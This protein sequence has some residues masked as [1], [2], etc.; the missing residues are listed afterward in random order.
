MVSDANFVFLKRREVMEIQEK[1]K[2]ALKELTKKREELY[3]EIKERL[4]PLI[5]M[6]IQ[7]TEKIKGRKAIEELY[8]EL[9]VTGLE[10]NDYERLIHELKKV[11]HIIEGWAP[12][13]GGF[14]MTM[15]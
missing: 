5:L 8:D 3:K 9:S 10:R 13:M 2:V 4:K 14:L 7:E 15:I 12:D 1:D 11:D 6:S